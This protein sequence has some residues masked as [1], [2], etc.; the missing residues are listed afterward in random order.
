MAMVEN[1]DKHDKDIENRA[2]ERMQ[3]RADRKLEA[4]IQ[5]RNDSM[6]RLFILFLLLG[7]GF[8]VCAALGV[9]H[10]CLWAFGVFFAPAGFALFREFFQWRSNKQR[11][12][13]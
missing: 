5:L 13:R 2:F 4:D 6:N 11:D 12:E 3:E 8:S 10:K 9:D 7:I 1:R